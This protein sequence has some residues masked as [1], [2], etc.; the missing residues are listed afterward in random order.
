MKSTH[1]V[2]KAQAR[3]LKSERMEAIVETMELLANRDFMDILRKYR[4]DTLEMRPLS[5]S[6]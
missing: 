6:F 1:P 2:T 4:A 5:T 3:L